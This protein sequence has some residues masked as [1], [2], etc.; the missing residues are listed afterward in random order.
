VPPHRSFLVRSTLLSA[1]AI[2][3]MLGAAPAER[4]ALTFEIT[5]EKGV[6]H[7][8]L[9]ARVFVMLAPESGKAPREGPD[10]MHPS[11]FFAV[12]ARDWKENEPLRIDGASAGFPRPLAQLKPG[13]YALQ[14]VVRLNPDTHA[15]GNGEGNAFGPI[16]RMSLDPE[17]SGTVALT[18]DRMVPPP[19]FQET[20]RIKLV[21]IP[22]P[23]LSAFHGRPIRHRAAVILP[24]GDRT[25]RRPTLYIV[26]GFGGDHH[27]AAFYDDAPPFQFGREMIRVVL[28]PDCGTGHHVFADSAANGPRGRALIEELI[29][30]IEKRFA[31]IAEPRARLLNGHSS[32]GW[33]TLWLQINYP[34]FFGGTWSTSPDPVDF[35]DFSAI[36]LYETGANTFRDRDGNR[37]PIARRGREPVLF[38]ESFSRMEDVYGDGGQLRSFEAV[39][40]PL[41]PDGRPRRLW[42]RSTGAVDPEVAR[43]WEAYDIRLVLERRWK[44]LGPKLAGKLHVITGALDTFYLEGAVKLLKQSL[45]ALGSDA[46]VEIVPGKDHRTI[47]DPALAARIDREM[48]ASLAK[49]RNPSE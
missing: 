40:S 16:K 37:R 12:D 5:R 7:G 14:A 2:V 24:D 17:T 13:R 21:D 29:P 44:T 11:P 8:P 35:R 38:F 30:H 22:S 42:D 15:L 1:L 9:S 49:T 6:R 10:W 39:F 19:Q 25:V 20:D 48:K 4:S 47:L 41:G 33:S 32:G 45:R 28:D 31:A 26:P 46:V 3:A 23:L 43:A 27:R 36:N 18:V 34:D